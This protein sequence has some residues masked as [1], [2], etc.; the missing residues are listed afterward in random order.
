MITKINDVLYYTAIDVSHMQNVTRVRISEAI[1]TSRI[2]GIVY[3]N[4]AY[5][6]KE[7]IDNHAATKS[8]KN[9]DKK[10]KILNFIKALE[11]YYKAS[12]E[13]KEIYK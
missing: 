3:C 11:L 5:A 4:R 13:L 6:D 2:K 12:E 8:D 7:F 9:K 1:K 10:E